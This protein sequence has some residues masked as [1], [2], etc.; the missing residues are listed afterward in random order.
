MGINQEAIALT[1]AYGFL[2]CKIDLLEIKEV[3]VPWRKFLS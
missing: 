1:F 2:A 3:I